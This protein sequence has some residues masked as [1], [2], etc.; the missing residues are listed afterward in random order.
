MT[1]FY[2]F[3]ISHFFTPWHKC[4]FAV[5]LL[6]SFLIHKLSHPELILCPSIVSLSTA[7]TELPWKKKMK[8][9]IKTSTHLILQILGI[10]CWQPVKTTHLRIT[11]MKQSGFLFEGWVYIS[12]NEQWIC[13][14]KIIT[15]RVLNTEWVRSCLLY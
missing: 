13:G 6:N 1:V 8:S 5:P 14:K 12:S 10:F 9:Q 11:K 2:T 4:E 7:Y 15:Q 3:S